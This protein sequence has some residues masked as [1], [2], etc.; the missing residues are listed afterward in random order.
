[1]TQAA[2]QITLSVAD[3]VRDWSRQER[4]LAMALRG[5]QPAPSP[6]EAPARVLPEGSLSVH[7]ASPRVIDA[8]VPWVEQP[9]GSLGSYE[10][11]P[12]VTP[13][14]RPVQASATP[15]PM[16]TL[17]SPQVGTLGGPSV[18]MF[19]DHTAPYSVEATT[20]AM[21]TVPDPQVAPI[22]P[23]APVPPAPPVGPFDEF[24]AA[25]TD[26]ETDHRAPAGPLPPPSRFM[27]RVSPVG[28][29][30][31]ATKRNYD[32]FEEL[33]ARLAAQAAARQQGASN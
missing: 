31:R 10:V 9:V 16:E 28:Q 27:V 15:V 18:D 23:R 7:V 25:V 17:M 20:P 13:A 22:A 12:A 30:H 33:N 1:M 3:R 29:P 32:Y 8:P 6:S 26:P 4:D 14:P 21:P 19:E 2:T 24:I 11:A 5:L